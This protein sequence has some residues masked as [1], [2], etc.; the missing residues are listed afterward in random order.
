[1][2]NVYG[3]EV[4]GCEGRAG[5]ASITLVKDIDFAELASYL[6]SVLPVY[7]IPLFLRVRTDVDTTGTFKFRKVEAVKEGFD[8]KQVNDPIWFLNPETKSY[9]AMNIATFKRISA[10]DY[11]F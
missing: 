9:A 2:A 4:P 10:K 1:M 7:A 5:M 11:Q 6:K 8:L 3:V